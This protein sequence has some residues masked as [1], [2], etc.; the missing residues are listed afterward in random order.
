MPVG[1]S[2]EVDFESVCLAC[3]CCPCTWCIDRCFQ[4]LFPEAAEYVLEAPRSKEGIFKDK[5]DSN[6]LTTHIFRVVG[7]LL[8][9]FGTALLFSPLI[10]VINWIPF[11]GWLIATGVS[12][13]VWIFALVFSV[14][15]SC[16]TIGLA[17]LYYR[18]LY[19]I[20]LLSVVALGLGT[21]F[22]VHK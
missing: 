9:F 3:E 8:M 14:T 10:Y 7:W 17:W 22:F 5:E 21:M 6:T 12:L 1:E 15:F 11:V 16:L 18:P 2:T 20:I 4:S 19:G 13:I